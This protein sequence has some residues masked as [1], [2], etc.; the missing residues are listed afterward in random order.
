VTPEDSV[1][2]FLIQEMQWT[3]SPDQLTQ[4]YALIENGVIDS[5]G[6]FALLGFIEK[7]F[8][9]RLA[10]EELSPDNFGTIGAITSLIERKRAPQ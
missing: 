2:E 7:E 9:V 1:R 6:L 4:D 3:G 8:G 5:L 10:G